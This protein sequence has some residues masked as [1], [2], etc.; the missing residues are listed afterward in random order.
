MIVPSLSFGLA[1]HLSWVCLAKADNKL[2]IAA[3]AEHHH[4]QADTDVSFFC[5]Q[6]CLDCHPRLAKQ[7]RQYWVAFEFN[8]SFPKVNG[9]LHAEPTFGRATH[10]AGNTNG[11]FSG[12]SLFFMQ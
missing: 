12:H 10:S 9:L 4:M 11:H 3:N 8:P 6:A 5:K 1:F 7:W 2:H